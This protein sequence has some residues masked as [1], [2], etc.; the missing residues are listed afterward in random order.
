MT[1][2]EKAKAQIELIDHL[3]TALCKC[4]LTVKGRQYLNKL[5][6]DLKKKIK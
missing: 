3:L 2:I 5:K 6:K 1:G 4:E